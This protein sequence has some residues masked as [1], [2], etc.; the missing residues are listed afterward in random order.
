MV[1]R[2]D[3]QLQA[4]FKQ[5]C[6]IWVQQPMKLRR[7][8][9]PILV[10]II[11]ITC[12]KLTYSALKFEKRSYYLPQSKW[13]WNEW[14]KPQ[15]KSQ[16]ISRTYF[17]QM[18]W[19]VHTFALHIFSIFGQ[20]LILIIQIGSVRNGVGIPLKGPP[21]PI[22]GSGDHHRGCSKTTSNS[23]TKDFLADR[24]SV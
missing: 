11:L 18:R 9:I 13:N 17:L 20:H 4:L 22:R 8:C 1:I 21:A 14:K 10:I 24:D 19:F 15:F 7:L 2:Y 3:L 6:V 16:N 12:R 23:K 5:N